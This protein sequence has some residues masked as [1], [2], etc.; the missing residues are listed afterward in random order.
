M[1]IICKCAHYS[2]HPSIFPTAFAISKIWGQGRF[3]AA[4]VTK[5]GNI[6]LFFFFFLL[7]ICGNTSMHAKLVN[8][9]GAPQNHP[10]SSSL[11]R[12][13]YRTPQNDP[14]LS[15]LSPPTENPKI[16]LRKD[17][18]PKLL[19]FSFPL[20]PVP[21]TVA[22]TDEWT[23]LFSPVFPHSNPFLRRLQEFRIHKSFLNKV[24]S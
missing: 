14:L 6:W 18:P 8:L 11:S 22:F 9:L 17:P 15:P 5:K 21:P 12:A 19:S 2:R 13:H 3:T 10:H 1:S 7:A 4:K 20:L 23:S 16:E 24:F